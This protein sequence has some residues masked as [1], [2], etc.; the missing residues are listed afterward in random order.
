MLTFFIRVFFLNP[1]RPDPRRR[2]KLT[3][4]FIFPLLCDA[5]E[6][7]MRHHKEIENKNL[8]FFLF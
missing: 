8:S 3:S 4:I 5:S 7:F 2:E 1:F 6:G